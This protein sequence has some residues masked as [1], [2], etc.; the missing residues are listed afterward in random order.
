MMTT[1]PRWVRLTSYLN[2]AQADLAQIQLAAEGISAYLENA[3]FLSWFWHYSIATGGVKLWV[4]EGDAQVAQ[5]VLWSWREAAPATEAPWQCLK[6]GEA[7]DPAWTTC[8]HCG[9][10]R[11]GEEDASFGEQPAVGTPP[12]RCSERTLATIV[13][14]SGPLVFLASRGSLSALAVWVVAVVWLRMLQN[15]QAADEDRTGSDVDRPGRP[16][17]EPVIEAAEPGT[18]DDYTQ[19]EETILRAWQAAV[20]SLWFSPLLLYSLWLL[21]ELALPASP[22]RPREQR[23]YIG[24]WVFNVLGLAQATFP[25]W[26]AWAFGR[27]Y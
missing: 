27:R 26:I 25:F 9:A 12:W 16:T 19:P 13:G 7:V 20:L 8:W 10:S 14:L 17:V 11:Y 23:R 2:V 24:A 15:W 3:A 1:A 18:A 21:W 6:C 22:L 5:T 4:L